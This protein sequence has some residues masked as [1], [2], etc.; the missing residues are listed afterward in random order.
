[1][2]TSLDG[3]SARKSQHGQGGERGGSIVPVIGV[4]GD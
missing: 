2:G 3:S 4:I 1:M